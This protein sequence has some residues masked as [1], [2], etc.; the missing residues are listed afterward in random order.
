MLDVHHR[1]EDD[2]MVATALSS[3]DPR[4][5]VVGGLLAGARCAQCGH[6]SVVEPPRCARCRGTMV[7]AHFGPEGTLWAT[8]TI[9]VSPRGDRAVPYTLGY[10]DVDDGPR[11]LAHVEDASVA[12]GVVA[13]PAVGQRARLSALTVGGDPQVELLR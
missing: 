5:R 6:P 10:V 1:R 2:L 12:D 13:A 3:A 9:H 11:L 8:T 7:P 4:P